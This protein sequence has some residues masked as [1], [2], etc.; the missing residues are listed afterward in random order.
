MRQITLG[1][2]RG[3]YIAGAFVP[4]PRVTV[5]T[6]TTLLL[7][8]ALLACYQPSEP[9]GS[10]ASLAIAPVFAPGTLPAA[11][12][13]DNARLRLFR[14]PTERALD[15]SV[16][17]P[18]A[19]TQI[20]VLLRVPLKARSE[21]MLLLAELRLGT[22][23]LYSGSELVELFAEAQGPTPTPRLIVTYV[24]PGAAVRALHITPRDT[25]ISFG[26]SFTFRVSGL[27][28][29]GAVVS[30]VVVAWSTTPA[31]A[32]SSAGSLTAP[33][34]RGAVKLRALTPAGVG[35]ST[36]VRF[37]PAPASLALVNGG[38]Q[39]GSTGSSLGNPFVVQV[40]GADGL[41][42]P[43]VPVRFRAITSGASVRDAVVISDDAGFAGTALTLGNV[44][45]VYLFEAAVTGV[46]VVLVSGTAF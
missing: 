34:A 45:G 40:R 32:V 22:Q 16:V 28:D 18:T 3:G 19:A 41:G 35:D 14:T 8:S 15:T 10:V 44:V 12:A 9:G 46:P 25:V 6:H 17:F 27:D 20:S 2:T 26:D 30:D 24:G 43:G 36:S 42:V 7:S 5:R 33:T 23:V 13:I 4:E 1:T 29:G 37:A 21:R 39:S 38:G 31:L 11:V